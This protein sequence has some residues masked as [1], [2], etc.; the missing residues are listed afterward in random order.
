LEVAYGKY[1]FKPLDLQKTY[2][3]TVNKGWD[4]TP[5]YNNGKFIEVPGIVAS[6]RST[7][8]IVS[9]ADEQMIFLKAFFAG[10]LFKKDYLNSMQNWNDTQFPPIQ[11]GTGLMHCGLPLWH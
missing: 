6:E 7:G 5:I 3:Q 2:L 8:G 10:K 9:N 1:I 11:Y 4:I